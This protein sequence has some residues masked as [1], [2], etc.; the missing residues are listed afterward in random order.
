M[1]VIMSGLGKEMAYGGIKLCLLDFAN[2]K[3]KER[4]GVLSAQFFLLPI[5]VHTSLA[6]PADLSVVGQW[7]SDMSGK[8]P[9][10]SLALQRLDTLL[11]SS[12]CWQNMHSTSGAASWKGYQ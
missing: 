2:A 6:F 4:K 5:P 12:Q 3:C 9:A 7:S 1:M 11:C 10:F 8:A